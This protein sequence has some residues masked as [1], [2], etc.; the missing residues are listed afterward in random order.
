MREYEEKDINSLKKALFQQRKTKEYW[1]FDSFIIHQMGVEFDGEI[2]PEKRKEAWKQFRKRTKNH[3]F[4]SIPTMQRWFGIGGYAH[5]K[6][7]QIFELIFFLGL[8]V[9][10][11]DLFLTQGLREPSVQVNDY[12][13][14]IFLYGLGNHL[15][16]EDC[17]KMIQEFEMQ[18][19]EE[20]EICHSQSTLELLEQFQLKK[21]LPQ[22]LFI[23]WMINNAGAFKGYSNTALEYLVKFKQTILKSVRRDMEEYLKE[24]LEDTDYYLW[25][26]GRRFRKESTGDA[27]R[28]YI[29]SNKKLSENHRKEILELVQC[30]YFEEASNVRLISEVFSTSGKQTVFKADSGKWRAIGRMTEKHLSDLLNIATQKERDIR[31]A[32]AESV[33]RELTATGEEKC[34]KWIEEL[35]EKYSGEMKESP[36]LEAAAAWIDKFRKEQ[37]RR[38]VL[39]QREDLLPFVLYVSEHRYLESIDFQMENYEAEQ[40]K[41]EF[42]VLADQTLAACSMAKLSEKYELDAVLLACFQADDMY[43]Y[44]E[45]LEAVETM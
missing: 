4:A 35:M 40:A 7:S 6:R 5:P 12:Q 33:L 25:L 34:P 23:E 1:R 27:I 41:Q 42:V 32:Q 18:M 31:T 20:L 22:E 13:E 16:Y 39:V 14:A 43:S 11:L 8:G 10:E 36:T 3:E 28:K 30:V 9:E 21:D 44:A 17:L 19:D 2:L 45:V 37:K 29:Y 38:C 15:G 26:E 24:I